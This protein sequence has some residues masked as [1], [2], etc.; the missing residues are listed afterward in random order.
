VTKSSNVILDLTNP[1]WKYKGILSAIF[2]NSEVAKYHRI[3]IEEFKDHV[4]EV[5]VIIY[6]DENQDW[7]WKGRIKYPSGS[8]CIIGNT[9][10]KNSNET[11]CLHDIYR[12]PLTDKHWFKNPLETAQS[13]LE[14]MKKEDLILSM[15]IQENVNT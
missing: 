15:K 12:L 7:I 6:V 5:F 14:I 10:G 8:K 2:D 1:N 13:L 11:A 4:A 9:L 3:S